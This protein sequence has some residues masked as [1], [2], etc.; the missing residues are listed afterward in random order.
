MAKATFRSPPLRTWEHGPHISET[1][2]NTHHPASQQKRKDTHSTYTPHNQSWDTFLFSV[3]A[4]RILLDMDPFASLG[5][6]TQNITIPWMVKFGKWRDKGGGRSKVRGYHFLSGSIALSQEFML[7]LFW[8]LTWAKKGLS[9]KE[10]VSA[11]LPAVS[12][13][14]E[15]PERQET[16][17]TES[18]QHSASAHH[19]SHKMLRNDTLI[20]ISGEEITEA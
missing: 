20:W 13:G 3:S 4:K 10:W 12:F 17:F 16:C 9:S 15:I 18:S 11:S 1:R 14:I 7:N 6:S 8:P 2:D 19:Q 5:S